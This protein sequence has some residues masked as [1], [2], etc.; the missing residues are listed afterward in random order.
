M[1]KEYKKMLN[2]KPKCFCCKKSLEIYR[3]DDHQNYVYFDKRL[4]HKKCFVEENKIKKK[5][6]FCNKDIDFESSKQEAVF[7]DKH[8]YHRDCFI[9]WCHDV[10]TVSKKRQFALE[11]IDD[12][13]IE[14]KEKISSLFERKKCSLD[15][16]DFYVNEADK[17]IKKVF[18]EL[19]LCCFIRE[20]YNIKTVPWKRII[21]IISGKTDKCNC[22]IPIE[23]LYDMWQ[24]KLNFL[25]KQNEKLT[26]NS[27]SEISQDNLIMYDLAILINKYNSYLKWKEQQRIL[28]IENE[29]E[30][31]NTETILTQTISS[32]SSPFENNKVN[33]SDDDEIADIVDDIFD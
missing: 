2:P 13:I 21:D 27:S 11:H 23:D 5:C 7:Y 12:Y 18:S 20:V 9:S 19:D 17:Y 26:H 1:S 25:K 10:K 33:I 24:R 6:Y 31:S 32:I 22:V 15:Q 29:K 16:I 30:N 3:N 14:C 8:F 28:E 4:Y